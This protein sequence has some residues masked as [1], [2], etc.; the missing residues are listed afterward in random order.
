MPVDTYDASHVTYLLLCHRKLWLHHHGMRMEDNSADVHV[1]KII[2]K[3]AYDRRAQ[4]WR[5]L[6]VGPVKIDHYD[7]KARL[8]R[9]V[10]KSP[11]LEYV[12]VAQVQ[13]YLWQMERHGV[14]GASGVIEYPKQRKT[15]PVVL[16]E[17]ARGKMIGWLSEIDRIVSLEVTPRAILKSYCGKCAFYDFCYC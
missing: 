12:H 11:K 2:G 14:T 15:V 3:N 5:E 6:V 17:E 10:K 13:Y 4:R 7:P 1:G 8:V 16:D 9:E